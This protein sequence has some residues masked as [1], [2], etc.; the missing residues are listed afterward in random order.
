MIGLF[1]GTYF[2][3]RPA[4]FKRVFYRQNAL[5]GKRKTFKGKGTLEKALEELRVKGSLNGVG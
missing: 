5:E 3:V 4:K 2:A 1:S